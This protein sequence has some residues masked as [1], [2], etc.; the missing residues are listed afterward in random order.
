VAPRAGV[1]PRYADTAPVWKCALSRA[2][3]VPAGAATTGSHARDG[4]GRRG[5]GATELSARA[6]GGARR[7]S[8]DRN[9][10][11]D[12]AARALKAETLDAGRARISDSNCAMSAP[13]LGI[14]APDAAASL[15]SPDGGHV[16]AVLSAWIWREPV[17]GR[18]SA[19]GTAGRCLDQGLAAAVLPVPA[20]SDE[21]HAPTEL[22][23]GGDSP[24]PAARVAMAGTRPAGPVTAD[25]AECAE[26][27]GPAAMDDDRP[28]KAGREGAASGAAAPPPATLVRRMSAGRVGRKKPAR[29]WGARVPPTLSAIASRTAARELLAELE[30]G[31]ASGRTSTSDK[32]ATAPTVSVRTRARWLRAGPPET[33]MITWVNVPTCW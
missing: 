5:A 18:G 3:T 31:A 19:T 15:L 14:S 27:G 22:E 6:S 11:V 2:I 4:A 25:P 16:A 32:A 28:N 8:S 10:S 24:L 29:R 20:V 30:A 1:R 9:S 12:L 26:G 23:L 13:R 21:R 17:L 7:E 33:H